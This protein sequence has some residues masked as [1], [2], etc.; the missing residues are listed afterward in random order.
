MKQ[1]IG[2]VAGRKKEGHC[3]NRH[4]SMDEEKKWATDRA[5]W[6]GFCKTHYMHA[7]DKFLALCALIKVNVHF[8][9]AQYPVSWTARSALHFTPLP[10]PT[11]LPGRILATLQF[12]AKTKSLTFPPPGT[13]LQLTGVSM[14]RAKIP[15]L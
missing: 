12:R 1:S 5:K 13:H 2:K 10:T 3:R 6:K 7:H 4:E 14:E 15:E 9:I 8:Y 11:R